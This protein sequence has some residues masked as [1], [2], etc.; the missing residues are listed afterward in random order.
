MPD[1]LPSLSRLFAGYLQEHRKLAFTNW[2]YRRNNRAKKPEL[3][4]YAHISTERCGRV[5]NPPISY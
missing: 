1:V 4:H 3:L 5:V 2:K